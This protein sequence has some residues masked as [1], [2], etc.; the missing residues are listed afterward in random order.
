M[1]IA[2]FPGA[3]PLPDDLAEAWHRVTPQRHLLGSSTLYFE[4][5]GSTNDVAAHVAASGAC[6]G[7]VVVAASQ[8]NGRGRRG[9]RWFSPPGAGLYVSV[10]MM[11]SRAAHAPDRATSLLTITAG[12]A[13]AEG[14]ERATGL[15]ADIKWPNDL[16][17]GRRKL[18]GILA[19]GV[20]APGHPSLQ[21]VVLGYGINVQGASYPPE[22]ADRVTALETELGRPVDRGVL[23]A[24]TLAA[25]DRRYRDLVGGAYDAILD[26]WRRRA[27]GS[28]QAR[29][30]WDA[31]SGLRHGTTVDIDASGALIVQTEQG[32]EH[33]TAGEVR[34]D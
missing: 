12:V 28:R 19:E 29:V 2:S 4:T 31:P 1:T 32:L 21:A 15:G 22:L 14:V 23:F 3:L 17:V 6:E 20:S 26:A 34:W 5:T 16:L 11:P 25:L 18:A 8:T 33:L 9:R 30:N 7:L 27:P 24:E 10:V 13:L